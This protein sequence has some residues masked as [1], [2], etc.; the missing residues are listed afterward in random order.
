MR[1]SGLATAGALAGNTAHQE[2]DQHMRAT[3]VKSA[4]K[5]TR[6]RCLRCNAPIEAGQAYVWAQAFRQQRRV[7]HQSCGG[8]QPWETEPN[9]KRAAIYHAQHDAHVQLD[10]LDADAYIDAEGCNAEGFVSDVQSV[11]DEFA[12]ALNEVQSMYE[13]SADNIEDGF[14]HETESSSE[15]R[16]LGEQVESWSSDVTD[17]LSSVGDEPDFDTDDD[18]GDAERDVD[19]D[20][21]ERAAARDEAWQTWVDEVVGAAS[22]AIDDC[23]I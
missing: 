22:D 10:G 23:P 7:V 19:A 5:Q 8:F 16:E 12:E 6:E 2:G 18:D 9:E 17:A 13:E 21:D 11:L 15:Q 1:A 20:D 4:R 3:Y 14:G